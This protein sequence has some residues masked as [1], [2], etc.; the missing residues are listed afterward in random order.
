MAFRGRGE[1]RLQRHQHHGRIV[2]IGIKVVGIF[3]APS[4]RLRLDGFGPIADAPDLSGH[5]PGDRL[6]MAG[7]SP[8]DAA[9]RQ[10]ARTVSAVS[11]MGDLQGWMRDRAGRFILEH[12]LLQSFSAIVDFGTVVGIAQHLGP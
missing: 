6:C 11:Q 5:Q 7:L 1:L 3:E 10:G 8:S 4:A 2:G 9:G 12:Q